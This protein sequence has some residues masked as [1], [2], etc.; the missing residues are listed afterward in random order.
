MGESVESLDLIND[1]F[2]KLAEHYPD[3]A[4]VSAENAPFWDESAPCYGIFEPEG[5]HY[6]ARTQLWFAEKAF[7]ELDIRK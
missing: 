5:G 3:A 6:T 4:V 2:R 1:T 7:A